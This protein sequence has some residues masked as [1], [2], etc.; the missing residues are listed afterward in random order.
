MNNVDELVYGEI[1][2][3]EVFFFVDGSDVV[4]FNFFI[5]NL[6]EIYGWLEMGLLRWVEVSEMVVWL[7]LFLGS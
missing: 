5:N 3:N 7:V 6:I 4:F 1:G 2:W